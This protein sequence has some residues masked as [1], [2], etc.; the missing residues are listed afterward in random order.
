MNSWEETVSKVERH[1]ES[2]WCPHCGEEFGIEDKVQC[3]R[4]AQAKRT[5]EIAFKA[6]EEANRREV[7]E[8]FKKYSQLERCD[9]DVMSY[10]NEYRW[11]DENDWQAKLKEWVGRRELWS[12]SVDRG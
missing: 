5:W 9:P 8:W 12:E 2:I 4:E 10:F 7:V 1:S 3:E 6:G 11:V